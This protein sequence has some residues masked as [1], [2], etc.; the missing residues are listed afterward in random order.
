[1]YFEIETVVKQ[2]VNLHQETM[3]SMFS[4]WGKVG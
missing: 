2:S 4:T 3:R 1:M